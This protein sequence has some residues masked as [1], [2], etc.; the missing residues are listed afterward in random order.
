[1]NEAQCF[2]IPTGNPLKSCL[3]RCYKYIHDIKYSHIPKQQVINS[4]LQVQSILIKYTYIYIKRCIKNI[5]FV[6]VCILHS[7]SYVIC[8]C[9]YID[10]KSFC[11]KQEYKYSL[12]L[13]QFTFLQEVVSNHCLDIKHCIN[14]TDPCCHTGTDLCALGSFMRDSRDEEDP[15]N[16]STLTGFVLLPRNSSQVG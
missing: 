1:M 14:L 7:F 9:V 5:F 12:G 10:F 6:Q 4:H 15:L 8:Y 3:L 16:A 11:S 13:Q 2:Y